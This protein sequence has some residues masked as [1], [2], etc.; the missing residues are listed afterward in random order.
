MSE[1]QYCIISDNDKIETAVKISS[2]RTVI[3]VNLFYEDQVPF[4]RTYLER[5]PDYIDIV[6]ISSK[7][8]ILDEFG[9]ERYQK[10][11]KAN[12]GR[13]IS[14]LLV[15]AKDIFFRYEYVCFIHDKKEKNQETK[16][17]VEQWRKNMWDNMLQSPT[18]VYNLLAL[19]ERNPEWGLLAPLPP[20]GRDMG[21]WLN[22]TWGANYDNVC[23]LAKELDMAADLVHIDKTP[24]VYSTA[25]WARSNALKKLFSK[26]WRY[27][28]FPD[29]PMK[30]D[31]E[32]NH[33]IERI[34][35]YVVRDAG[36]ETKIALSSSFAALFIEKLHDEFTELWEQLD[37][38]VGIRSYK[39]LNFYQDRVER[40]KKFRSECRDIYL[41]GIGK[42][43]RKCLRICRL[44]DIIPKGIIVTCP[45]KEQA[46]VDDIPVIGISDFAFSQ[47]IG[48]IIS[49]GESY[50]QEIENE[51]EKRKIESYIFF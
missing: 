33:A 11:K 21:A 18:Y 48:I 6:I 50:Q 24:V 4:Y 17:Y 51:L 35:E 1:E 15:A 20:H 12:R 46:M 31:G 13:D 41:Y 25:F 16:G 19:M 2:L 8:M 32:L 30:N 23:A 5:I 7:N 43:G 27:S 47:G 34:L 49:V 40:I 36:Y 29:E 45:M 10:I 37:L 3:L 44:F 26:N 39:E 14:A 42:V 28:D 38:T 9:G 22:G